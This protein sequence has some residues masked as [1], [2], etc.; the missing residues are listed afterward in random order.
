MS[1][2]SQG[3]ILIDNC[4][5]ARICDFGRVRIVLE[6]HVSD[7]GLKT[8]SD[9]VG[10]NAY[11]AFELA[12]SDRALPTAASDIYALGCLGLEV[13]SSTG[14]EHHYCVI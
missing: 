10:A 3:N 4:G 11:P 2:S 9:H 7:D 12:R 6:E 5:N 8:T 14:C 1:D 13:G